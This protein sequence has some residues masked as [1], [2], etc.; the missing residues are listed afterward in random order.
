MSHPIDFVEYLSKE[1]DLGYY[2]GDVENREVFLNIEPDRNFLVELCDFIKEEYGEKDEFKMLLDDG[3]LKVVALW[4]SLNVVFI[5]D[6][7]KL[8]NESNGNKL[9]G[10]EGYDQPHPTNIPAYEVKHCGLPPALREGRNVKVKNPKLFIGDFEYAFDGP[11]HFEENQKHY[12]V[13]WYR[14]NVQKQPT[15][16]KVFDV[17]LPRKMKIKRK[18]DELGIYSTSIITKR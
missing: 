16:T 7:T 11:I 3:G 9:I 2:D 17:N 14:L 5:D 8:P 1:Y 12:D 18:V 13:V 10:M 6:S 15:L 4:Y